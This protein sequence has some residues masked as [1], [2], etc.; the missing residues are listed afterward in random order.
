MTSFVYDGIP[1]RKVAP[2]RNFVSI[3]TEPIRAVRLLRVSGR[4]YT[5]YTKNSKIRLMRSVRCIES[6]Y[7]NGRMCFPDVNFI[8]RI[9][10]D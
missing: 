10:D 3:I 6:E 8:E 5:Y 2:T 4:T 9:D 1:V 7:L